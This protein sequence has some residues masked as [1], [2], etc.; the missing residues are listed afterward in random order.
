M[1]TK[2][3]DAHGQSQEPSVVTYMSYYSAQRKAAVA[4]HAGDVIA[5]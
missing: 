3:A 5:I 1:N 4:E 2:V